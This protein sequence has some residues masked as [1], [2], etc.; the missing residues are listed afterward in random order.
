MSSSHRRDRWII[1]LAEVVGY[2]AAT[3]KARSAMLDA[4]CR[5]TSAV[6][7]RR[8]KPELLTT[9]FAHEMWALFEDGNLL[10]DTRLTGIHQR[11]QQAADAVAV[12]AAIEDARE[13]AL[14]RKLAQ[15]AQAE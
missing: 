4:R 6:A 5:T 2:A 8:R 15:E 13:E 3:T 11:S 12:M 9:E 14:Q 7:S 10:A 1:D